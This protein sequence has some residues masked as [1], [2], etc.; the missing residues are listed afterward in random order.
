M[1]GG[2]VDIWRKF[3]ELERKGKSKNTID[4]FAEEK[5]NLSVL[6]RGSNSAKDEKGYLLADSHNCLF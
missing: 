4:S 5:T 2:Y 1:Q 6:P 3:N